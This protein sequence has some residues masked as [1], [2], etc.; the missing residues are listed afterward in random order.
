MD[1]WYL[2]ISA[3]SRRVEFPLLPGSD[4]SQRRQVGISLSDLSKLLLLHLYTEISL[5]LAS[6][7]PALNKS[8]SRSDT[9]V[10]LWPFVSIATAPDLPA[11]TETAKQNNKQEWNDTD[12]DTRIQTHVLSD[13]T[14]TSSPVGGAAAQI[15]PKWTAQNSDY[16]SLSVIVYRK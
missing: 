5:K 14:N 10:P 6:T 13:Q 9:D 11:E 15:F 1:F 16:R 2:C 12:T 8:G 3:K 7:I 4:S